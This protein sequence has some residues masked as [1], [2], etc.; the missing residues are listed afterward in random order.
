MVDTF[1]DT[2]DELSFPAAAIPSDQFKDEF[3]A[4]ANALRISSL[5]VSCLLRFRTPVFLRK[6]ANIDVRQLGLLSP[7]FLLIALQ[8]KPH[9]PPLIEHLW[10]PAP[11][12]YDQIILRWT[13]STFLARPTG[14]NYF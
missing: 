11:P 5:N 14:R 10:T 6:Y 4:S 8:Y 7:G 12:S 13:A 2:F 9:V 3:I 1:P